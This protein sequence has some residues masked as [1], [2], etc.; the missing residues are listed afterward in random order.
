[1]K[2][3]KYSGL[4]LLFQPEKINLSQ[5]FFL[6]PQ[7]ESRLVHRPHLPV[8]WHHPE[9]ELVMSAEPAFDLAAE[10]IGAWAVFP[11]RRKGNQLPA[12]DCAKGVADPNVGFY[13]DFREGNF[14]GVDLCPERNHGTD[15]DLPLPLCLDFVYAHLVP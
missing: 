6:S 7:E 13:G 2:P 9:Q 14:A 4:S 10:V 11:G 3:R 5:Y 8:F 12:Y 15:R 1:M